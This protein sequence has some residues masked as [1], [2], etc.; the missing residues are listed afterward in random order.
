MNYMRMARFFC[1]LSL[2]RFSKPGRALLLMPLLLH[3][4]LLKVHTDCVMVEKFWST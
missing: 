2:L 1:L 3:G 4:G